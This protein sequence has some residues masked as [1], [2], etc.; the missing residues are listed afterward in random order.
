M[1]NM[2]ETF[3]TRSCL[4]DKEEMCAE[5]RFQQHIGL[6]KETKQFLL[7]DKYCL[8]SGVAFYVFS[9]GGENIRGF[10][11]LQ[12]VAVGDKSVPVALQSSR[13]LLA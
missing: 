11:D 4:K 3:G 8:P 6:K 5:N 12:L 13:C 2:M 1:G 9:A 10:R 7:C